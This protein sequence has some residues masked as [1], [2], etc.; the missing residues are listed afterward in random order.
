M[1]IKKALGRAIFRGLYTFKPEEDLFVFQPPSPER[2]VRVVMMMT[3]GLNKI[4]DFNPHVGN[5]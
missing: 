2:L 1:G 3:T 5:K 4:H